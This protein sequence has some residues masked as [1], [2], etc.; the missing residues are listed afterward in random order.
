M[1]SVT[2]V[3]PTTQD[4]EAFNKRIG[5]LVQQQDYKGQIE[6]LYDYGHEQI[7]YKLNRLCDAANGDIIMRFDSDD[8]YAPDYVTKTAAHLLNTKAECTGLSNAFFYKPATN[9]MWRYDYPLGQQFVLG[10][11]LAFLRTTWE[12]SPFKDDE[13][14]KHGGLIREDAYFCANAGRL[15]PHD[16]INNFCAIRHNKNTISDVILKDNS[17]KEINPSFARIILGNDYHK[18]KN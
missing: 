7:G 4:R 12:R 5:D 18:F 17:F 16:N 11:T 6:H 15:I 9:Q 14:N 10:A 13:R 1:V 8:F 3:T 2:I